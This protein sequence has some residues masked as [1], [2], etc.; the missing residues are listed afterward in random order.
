MPDNPP[1]GMPSQASSLHGETENV[2]PLSDQD[3]KD[4]IERVI[5]TLR[6]QPAD[7]SEPSAGAP[8]THGD[9]APGTAMPWVLQQ[10]FDGQIDLEEE[11]GWR[12]HNMPVMATIKFRRMGE[13]ETRRVA[14]LAAQD[15]SAQ[16][17][18]YA[19]WQTRAISLAYTLGGMLTLRFHLDHLSDMDRA[20]WLG[21]VRREASGAA[22]LWGAARWERDYLICDARRYFTNLYA[23]SP[24][25]IEAAARLTPDVAAQLFDWLADCWQPDLPADDSALLTW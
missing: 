11:L 23:F 12:F 5:H 19:D 20:H 3:K 21:L 10:F 22:F 7:D 1:T 15:G 14:A 13:H 16:L 17:M 25:Q 8:A 24:R 18:I 2:R 4:I 9:P 6:Q